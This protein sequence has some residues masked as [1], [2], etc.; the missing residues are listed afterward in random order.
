M[1][2]KWTFEDAARCWR[3]LKDLETGVAADCSRFEE[4]ERF[5]LR[6]MPMTPEQADT[7]IAVIMEQG[8]ER[9][10][11][12]D[13]AALGNLRTFIRTPHRQAA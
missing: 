5:L 7:V 12:L 11:G 13:L 2:R 1:G 9:S 3:R 10:D 4:A 6:H 8:A